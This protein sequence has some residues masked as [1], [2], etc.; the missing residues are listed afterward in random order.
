MQ[1]ALIIVNAEVKAEGT[2]YMSSPATEKMVFALEQTIAADSPSTQVEVISAATLWSKSFNLPKS[3]ANVI[4][5]PLT[6]DI[7]N[8]LPFPG[9]KIYQECKD[10]KSQRLWVEKN[11]GYKTSLKDS[12]LG[13]LWLPVAL[14]KKELIYGEVIGEGFFPNSYQQ[15]V[16]FESHLRRPL[17]DLAQGLLDSLD[18]PPS[19]YLIQFRLM[20]ETIV[21][22]RLWPFPAAPTIAS[23]N[24]QQSNLFTCYWHCLTHQPIVDLSRVPSEC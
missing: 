18:A 20:G 3:N 15:P 2:V 14:T 7:P 8:W 23:L 13:N 21:F 5:C 19:V 10:V 11:L 22:D 17:Y 12:C 1:K 4:Y 16:D 9:Q 24:Y 6:I